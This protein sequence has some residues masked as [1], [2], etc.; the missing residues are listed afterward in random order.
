MFF[1]W[2]FFEKKIGQLLGTIGKPVLYSARLIASLEVALHLMRNAFAGIP[3]GLVIVEAKMVG[4]ITPGNHVRLGE[5]LPPL[6]GLELRGIDC[7][8]PEEH[9]TLLVAE[10]VGDLNRQ[11]L[12]QV[13]ERDE[14]LRRRGSFTAC[15]SG[16]DLEDVA[17]FRIL[18]ARNTPADCRRH[19]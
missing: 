15:A 16:H 9:H 3:P 4:V 13:V 5:K 11:G 6:P 1:V 14:D 12:G 17:G 7:T 10:V 2:E 19:V 18:G 8:D